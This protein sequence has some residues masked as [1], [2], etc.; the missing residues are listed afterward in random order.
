MKQKH[1]LRIAAKP[2]QVRE[3]VITENRDV[4]L[5]FVNH[6]Q[7]R[8]SGFLLEQYL[9]TYPPFEVHHEE[10]F[11][12]P[13]CYT[14]G[15]RRLDDAHLARIRAVQEL[16]QKQAEVAEL[17]ARLENLEDQLRSTIV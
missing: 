8:R 9:V 11:I 7:K 5:Q 12:L 2:T 15:R 13:G 10:L 16:R 1:Q 4:D 3:L 17:A 6:G 14:F